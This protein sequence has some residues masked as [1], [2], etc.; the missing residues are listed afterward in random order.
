VAHEIN[1]PLEAIGNLL[2]LLRNAVELNAEARRYVET[3]Q[4]ELKR[5]SEIT[6]LTLGMQRAPADHHESVQLAKLLENVLT[7]YERKTRTL[8]IE[9]QRKYTYEGDV[10]GSLGELRQVFSNLIVN[11]MDALAASGSK[12]VISVHRGRRWDTGQ[13]GVRISIVDDGPGIA[14]EHR[15]QLFQAFYTTKGEQGT[16]IGLWVTKAIVQKH[17]GSLRVHSS[18]RPGRSG[19]CFSVFLPL[20]SA[21]ETKFAA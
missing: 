21:A 10:S 14:P 8:G 19:A 13:Q 5:V 4:E 6:R 3:A 17:R 7:L 11:A 2:F 20:E 1:N 9:V 15:S 18:V 12:L 16:G